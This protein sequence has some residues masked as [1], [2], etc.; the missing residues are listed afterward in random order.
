MK[1]IY[2][3]LTFIVLF[4]SFTSCEEDLIVYD[5]ASFLQLL[6]DSA[7]SVVEN[8][9]DVIE[10]VAILG[11]A[12]STD[13]TVSFSVTGDDSRFT[14]SGSS[15]V[16]PAGETSGTITFSPID[17]ETIDGDTVVVIGLADSNG[18]PVGVGGEGIN[19]VNKTI[20]LIDD[21]V[22]CNN[23]VITVVSDRWGSEVMYDI[24]DSNGAVVVSG[25]PF[26]DTAAGT[27]TTEVVNVNLPDGCYTMRVFDWYGD[28]WGS[29]GASYAA[30]CGALVAGS[31]SGDSFAGIS[32]LDLSTVPVN[33]AYGT[34]F[35]ASGNDVDPYAGHA[36]SF[37]FCVNP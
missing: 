31:G 1:N 33:P 18:L 28:S 10:I 2:K 21:N 5:N 6:D 34:Q 8:S 15:V 7:V 12:Q 23:Y 4:A 35:R 37:D 11:S 19:S 26:S 16:I 30:Q 32:G 13:T 20:T 27:N 29:G 25:G 9:G 14:I 22:P 24:L 3:L 36:D 17:N